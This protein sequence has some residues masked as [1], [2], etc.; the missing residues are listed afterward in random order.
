[1]VSTWM[2]VMTIGF[3][4]VPA[5]A[6][7]PQAL[8]PPETEVRAARNAA[9]NGMIPQLAAMKKRKAPDRMRSPEE[10]KKAGD[11]FLA[12]N[13]TKEGVVALPSG[14]QY[15]VLKAGGGKTPTDDD[16]VDCLVR[17][18]HIDNTVF[19][20]SPRGK[21]STFK[22]GGTI[23]GL[24]QALKLMPVGSKWQLIIPPGLAYGE[25]GAAPKIGPNETLIY[26]VELIAVK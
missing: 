1:M 10:N 11:A 23:P 9:R 4:A 8:Q 7:E 21:P 22:V 15:K 19:G 12:E 25:K 17:A 20:G 6:G 5:V 18:M 14:L 13:R 26:E 3:L 2:V 24:N 16:T